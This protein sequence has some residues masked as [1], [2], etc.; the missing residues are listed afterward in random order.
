MAG[1]G[2]FCVSLT[3]AKND[4]DKATVAFVVA[5]AA[6]GSDQQTL[7]F[8]STEAV[9]LA[10]VGLRRRHP[11]GGLPAAAGADGRTSPGPAARSSSAHRAS[12]SG[13]STTATWSR[14]PRSSAGPSSWSSCPTARPACPTE[15]RRTM[16]GHPYPAAV[17]FDGGDLDCGSGLLLLIR[18]HIDPLEQGQL[19]EILSVEPS[20]EE[21]LPAWCRLTGNQLVNF[22]EGRTA[23]SASWSARARSPNRRPS[24]HPTPSSRFRRYGSA[25]RPRRT[26][27]PGRT[28][29]GARSPSRSSRP[30]I[31]DRLPDPAPAPAVEPLSVMGVGSWPRPRWLRR[32]LHDHLEGRMPDDE[33][34]E[35]RPTTPSAW[36]WRPSCGPGSTW[37]PTAS[38]AATTT[39]ASSAGCCRTAS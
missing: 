17:S 18:K 39:P 3:A 32:A 26:R 34:A 23:S 5:N 28:P 30:T 8:L 4:T 7:V 29:P 10:E 19:L 24:P 38:S 6:V 1:T 21:D 16:P 11:R 13:P 20:V 33:F 15:G 22:V 36:P 14:A 37:S 25:R 31:P 12:R 9:R 35:V 2:K 27:P